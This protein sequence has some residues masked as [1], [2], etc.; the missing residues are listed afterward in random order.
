MFGVL[1]WVCSLCAVDV[2]FLLSDSQ[3][4]YIK[5]VYGVILSNKTIKYLPKKL[6]SFRNP[7]KLMMTCIRRKEKKMAG[8]VM[9]V[10]KEI[11]GRLGFMPFQL[12]RNGF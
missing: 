12:E 8:C 11:T 2:T 10:M 3:T 7:C 6:S 9:V 1:F 4:C 5:T